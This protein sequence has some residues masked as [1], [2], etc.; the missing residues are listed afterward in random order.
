MQFKPTPIDGS[1]EVTI[2]KEDSIVRQ[3][4]T[5]AVTRKF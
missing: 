2:E 4:Q 3:G 5:V 1:T